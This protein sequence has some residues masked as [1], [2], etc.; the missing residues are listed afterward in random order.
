M[1]DL[2]F[3]ND[4]ASTLA[5]AIS[6]VATTA[7]LQVGTGALFPNPT[8]SEY[9]VMTFTDAG[10]GLLKE[11]VHVT[12]RSGDT[13]T[14]ERAQEGTTALA[15]Q[16]GDLADNLNTAGSMAALSQQIDTAISGGLFLGDGGAPDDIQLTLPAYVASIAQLDG[17]PIRILMSNGNTGST[18]ISIVGD[19]TYP[20]LTPNLS[21][22]IGGQLAA[23]AVITVVFSAFTSQFFLQSITTQ[24]S[25]IAGMAVILA[26]GT[27]PFPDDVDQVRVS[28]TGGGG[29]AGGGDGTFAG[30]GGAA[31]GTARKTI[32]GVASLTATVT[33]GAAGTGGAAAGGSQT[34]G[35][36]TSFVLGAH[37][38]VGN[39]GAAGQHSAAPA[40]GAGGTAT[41]GTMNITGGC[42]TDGSPSGTVSGGNGGAS[43]WG[44][45]GRASTVSSAD[46]DGQAYGS[47][48]GGGYG[49]GSV[50][51]GAGKQGVIVLEWGP[52]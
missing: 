44:G 40:G 11:I 17:A 48:G 20:L 38:V 45:G 28:A 21:E 42:G 34:A 22:L 32:T 8:G 1:P 36:N 13:I 25:P 10:T 12:A 46:Q 29:G 16:A 50:T 18:T 5:G 49:G 15:W 3:A 6:N 52:A 37:N 39:G 2:L 51:G 43:Y 30:S 14:I 41:G 4:A 24:S 26:S 7:N 35:G 27:Y 33:V 47:G 9:F 31:G 23:A 19:T